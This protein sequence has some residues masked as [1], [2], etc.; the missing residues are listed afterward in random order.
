MTLSATSIWSYKIRVEDVPEAGAHFDL[1][2]DE[3]TR[4]ALAKAS[5]LRDLPRLSASFDVTRK[6]VGGV[7]VAGAVRALVG[8]NCVVTLDPVERE[9]DEAI[10]LTFTPEAAPAGTQGETAFEFDEDEPPETI[11]GGVVDLGALATEFLLLGIDPYPRK[12]GVSFEPRIAGDPTS[13]PFAALASLKKQ[14]GEG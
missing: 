4:A 6:G 3:A 9:L 14:G 8:Q 10:D 2:A 11:I 1:D 13:H 5:G 7:H 12:E